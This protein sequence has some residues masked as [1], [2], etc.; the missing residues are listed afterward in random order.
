M[1]EGSARRVCTAEKV[2]S[3]VVLEE[4]LLDLDMYYHVLILKCQ[5]FTKYRSVP[6]KR[7]Q[8]GGNNIWLKLL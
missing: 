7:L 4:Q 3:F 6:L 1:G 5:K 8:L 2:F